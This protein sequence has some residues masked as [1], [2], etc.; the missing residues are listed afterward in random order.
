[1]TKTSKA[2][3]NALKEESLSIDRVA[4]LVSKLGDR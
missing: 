3:E 2:E 4:E 1:L